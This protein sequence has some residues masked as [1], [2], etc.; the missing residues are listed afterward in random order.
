MWT[1]GVLRAL[2]R[3]VPVW[4]KP[5]RDR[6]LCRTRLRLGNRSLRSRH[7]RLSSSLNR[8]S[9]EP[10]QERLGNGIG[11]FFKAG[12]VVCVNIRAEPGA[13]TNDRRRFAC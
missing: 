2:L 5:L 13:V 10:G 8:P 7:Q 4:T 12:W 1:G 9:P 6:E 11:N 3:E